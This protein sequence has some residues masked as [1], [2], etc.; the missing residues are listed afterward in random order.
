MLHLELLSRL[1]DRIDSAEL[2]A[3]IDDEPSGQ[4]ARRIGF[5]YEWL[6]GRQLAVNASMAVPYVDVLDERKLVAAF[7]NRSVPNRRGQ[8]RS[9]PCCD[10]RHHRDAGPA[11]RSV[12]PL[13]R[14]QPRQAVERAGQENP[15]V[16]RA[17]LV[18]S[19]R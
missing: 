16:G 6:T 7:L 12:H 4:Y 17:G 13:G 10:Q 11:D 14:G 19:D 15:L 5:L 3:W 8:P 2:V 9:S 1:F 18:D